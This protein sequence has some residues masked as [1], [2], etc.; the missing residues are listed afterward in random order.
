MRSPLMRA[1]LCG[2]AAFLSRLLNGRG[3]STRRRSRTCGAR[4]APH[5][6]ALFAVGLGSRGILFARA[7]AWLWC[8]PE[9][10]EYMPD[11][12]VVSDVVPSANFGERREGAATDMIVLHY[13]GMPDTDAALRRLTSE[14]TEVSTHYLIHE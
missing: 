4:A 13:T 14:G 1:S 9:M 8:L 11:S 2:C 3:P 10:M 12:S 5:C 6:F 7:S